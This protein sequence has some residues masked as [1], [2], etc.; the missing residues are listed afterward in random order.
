MLADGDRD[1]RCRYEQ[2]EERTANLAE[3]DGDERSPALGELVAA[4][5]L[6]AG[7]C[8]GCAQPVLARTEPAERAL[9]GRT[10]QLVEQDERSNGA[11]LAPTGAAAS[12]RTIATGR[13]DSDS[14]LRDTLPISTLARVP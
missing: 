1:D 2:A 10:G 8:L 12:P 14:T 6:E 4:V 9:C 11:Q 3:Q 13:F 5:A 7:R